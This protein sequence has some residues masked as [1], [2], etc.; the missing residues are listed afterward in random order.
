M[1]SSTYVLPRHQLR[2]GSELHATAALRPEK[3]RVVP[4][5]QHAGWP[6]T[7]VG[8]LEKRQISCSCL[9]SNLSVSNVQSISQLRCTYFCA[10]QAVSKSKWCTLCVLRHLVFERLITATLRKVSDDQTLGTAQVYV[11]QMQ[12]PIVW[13]QICVA[14][15]VVQIQTDRHVGLPITCVRM[16]QILVCYRIIFSTVLSTQLQL[17]LLRWLV[18]VQSVGVLNSQ[19]PQ[20][21]HFLFNVDAALFVGTQQRHDDVDQDNF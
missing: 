1:Y 3:G 8:T 10:A 4:T 13:E 2:L 6:R 20:M 19:V 5:E 14:R 17:W 16:V 15:E 9:E 7:G 18:S 11:Q 21:L 12:R